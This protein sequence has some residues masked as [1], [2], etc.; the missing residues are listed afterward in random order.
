MKI[1]FI[2]LASLILLIFLIVVFISVRNRAPNTNEAPLP[3]IIPTPTPIGGR[4]PAPNSVKQA[5]LKA[6]STTSASDRAQIMQ[7][8]K[9]LPYQSAD[10]TIVQDA[11]MGVI[12]ISLKSNQAYDTL[13]Q[14]LNARG[15]LNAYL[16]GSS[17][18]ITSTRPIEAMRADLRDERIYEFG[19]AA[20][21]EAGIRKLPIRTSTYVVSYDHNAN[22][23]TAQI[24][25]STPEQEAD[26]K[27]E[28][29]TR[30]R[31][32]NIP[33]DSLTILYTTN[34]Q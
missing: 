28:I 32:L 27:A 24:N 20:A 15:V 13:K 3:T 6:S 34:P 10:F 30:L 5:I 33:L 25:A 9:T 7:F 26:I 12:L 4:G 8:A 19:E 22:A 29:I 21:E 18:F 31:T 2:V 1:R 23:L 14:F 17:L 16:K 11:D